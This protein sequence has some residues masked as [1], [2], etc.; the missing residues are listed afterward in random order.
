M[1][2]GFV[3]SCILI[4]ETRPSVCIDEAVAGST[5]HED[6]KQKMQC[7]VSCDEISGSPMQTADAGF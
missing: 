5:C 3:Q 7:S 4:Q 2:A 1:S 6:R